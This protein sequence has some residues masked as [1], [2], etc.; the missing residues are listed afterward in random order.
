MDNYCFCM[1]EYQPGIC[2]CS[3]FKVFP[4][5]CVSLGLMSSHS[6]PSCLR[7]HVIRRPDIS[8]PSVWQLQ[9]CVNSTDEL[10]R[11]IC[12]GLRVNG[13]TSDSLSHTVYNSMYVYIHSICVCVR[14]RQWG[15]ARER[16]A[17]GCQCDRTSG[18]ADQWSGSLDIT[19]HSSSRR[20]L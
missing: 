6:L 17:A 19:Q 9:E 13:G 1:F 10:A 2:S 15:E 7:P 3:H 11:I 18:F 14:S 12:V 4:R 8:S 16:W 20:G 5:S